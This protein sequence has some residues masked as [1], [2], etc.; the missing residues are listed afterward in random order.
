MDCLIQT[1]EG[2][3][4]FAESGGMALGKEDSR[5]EWKARGID[6]LARHRVTCESGR[7]ILVVAVTNRASYGVSVCCTGH[8]R[9]NAATT[10]RSLE[11][12]FHAFWLDIVL[13]C[14]ALSSFFFFMLFR[15]CVRSPCAWS[16]TMYER[17]GAEL[18]LWAFLQIAPLPVLVLYYNLP[19]PWL[20]WWRVKFNDPPVCF[21]IL[22][23]CQGRSAVCVCEQHH[24]VPPVPF[25]V[26]NSGSYYVCFILPVR[27][28]RSLFS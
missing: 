6:V 13:H 3:T 25:F 28:P 21:L 27:P 23:Q 1:R 11:P 15:R 16:M 20:L 2:A 24:S 5:G 4:S 22:L 26:V 12:L 18:E 19:A 9:G 17:R 14:L 8:A 7:D 10:C